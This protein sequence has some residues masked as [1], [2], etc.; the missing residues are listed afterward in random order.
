MP[1]IKKRI[2]KKMTNKKQGQLA[3]F[4]RVVS[5]VAGVG[6]GTVRL[7]AAAR[8]RLPE[9]GDARPV[10]LQLH[11]PVGAVRPDAVALLPVS[12]HR[13]VAQ[14]AGFVSKRTFLRLRYDRKEACAKWTIFFVE[15]KEATTFSGDARGRKTWSGFRKP[16]IAWIEVNKC[17]LRPS[18]SPSCGAVGPYPLQD[19]YSITIFCFDLCSF[20]Q[21][22]LTFL[23]VGPKFYWINI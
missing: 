7:A 20:T 21:I 16:S 10:L 3:I 6:E 11:V 22:L 2:E 23:C 9:A 14:R 8:L 5:V 18:G 13:F 12:A 17:K 4:V 15:T 1:E 19:P